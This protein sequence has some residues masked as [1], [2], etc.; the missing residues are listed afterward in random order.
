MWGN[1]AWNLMRLVNTGLAVP[2][3][4]VL[5]TA[6][7]RCV[8]NA[9]C[10]NLR[11]MLEDGIARLETASGLGFGSARRPLLVSARSGSAVSMPGML[12]TVLDV[13]LNA[14]TVDGILRLT[15]NPR[16]AWDSYRRFVQNYA[17]VV[18][19]LAAAPFQVLVTQ[20]VTRKG[21]KSERELD[22]RDLRAITLAMLER[23]EEL[24]GAPVP[25]EPM[26]QL[27]QAVL[28]VF[29]SW[30]APKAVTYR[31]LNR[32]S[33]SA[34]TAV[35]V[36]M[37][38]FGNFGPRSGAG[39][40]FTRDPATGARELYFDFC[41]KGQGEDVVSGRHTPMDSEHLRLLLPA[42]FVELQAV[43]SRL[44]AEFRDVQDFE[45]TVQE[46][47]LWL[48]QTRDA[49][50]TPWAALRVAVDMVEEGLITPAEALQRLAD[51]DLSAVVRTR[52]ALPLPEPLAHATVAGL[53]VS[54]GAIALD[55]A[56][57][58]RLVSQ[59]RPTVLVRHET[60]TSD[61]AGVAR[62]AGILTVAGGR[63]S[64][65][66]V[67]ARQLGKVCLVGCRELTIDLD[68][69][70]CR[71]GSLQLAEG[72]QISLDGNT[73]AIYPGALPVLHERPERELAAVASWG[74]GS[75]KSPIKRE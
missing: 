4:F 36:Q 52:F 31:R 69:R 33:D 7:S 45:F 38:V 51:V 72:A 58:E 57:A 63:T 68:R 24:A 49:K 25:S 59:G 47:R 39:V 50:R 41:L 54:S 29:R 20:E 71:F 28:A 53:G 32:L 46:G 75:T 56:A 14:T 35:T 61:I 21:A 43:G 62:A 65:G 44:E 15:G 5:P 2:P 30:D 23:Y 11:R 26:E 17:K 73:G 10:A 42:V 67:V 55:T 18:A 27:L 12:E 64:H 66:A 60:E 3:A 37:M 34:G 48:L 9:Q 19:G 70:Q 22:Y 6:W 40:G 8:I 13:G 16:L 1:K 74:T